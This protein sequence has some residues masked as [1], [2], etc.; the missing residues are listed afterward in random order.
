VGTTCVRNVYIDALL[1]SGPGRLT[2]THLSRVETSFSHDQFTRL[3][4]SEA[5]C[6]EALL[7]QGTRLL[8]EHCAEGIRLLILDDTIIEKPHSALSEAVGYHYDHSQGRTLRGI[9]VL[10][11]L[12]SDE[13]LSVPLM[14]EVVEKM[15][16]GRDEKRRPVW[17]SKHPKNDMFRDLV[18]RVLKSPARAVDYVVSDIWFA[19]TENMDFI[20]EDMGVDFVMAVKGNR[21]VALTKKDADSGTWRPLQ[22]IKLGR[23]A[24]RC[25]LKGLDF[26][27]LVAREVFK[28]GG[29]ANCGTLYLATS[30]LELRGA[31]IL[32]L[33]QRRW[34]IE[35]YHRSLKQNCCAGGAQVYHP[36]A[37]QSHL[38][39]AAFAFI[40]LEKAR[41]RLDKN[42]Y[43]LLREINELKTKHAL[44]AIR[45]TIHV[46]QNKYQ[47][48]A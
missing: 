47:M 36:Q 10:S 23:G 48:A 28:N 46:N 29:D 19:S 32:G 33:Y 8:R 43:Q 1:S 31:D 34:K 26:P 17:A 9:N 4:R 15:V 14:V 24:L 13:A 3:L 25:Y 44:K 6:K 35:E 38:R 7:H 11:A 16:C 30:D 39:L 41:C 37:H 27:V 42:H 5:A 40:R 12:W 18:T 2:A 20:K 45:Q 22:T 21:L